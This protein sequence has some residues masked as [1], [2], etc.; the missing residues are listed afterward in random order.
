M[1]N[2]ILK[3]ETSR[4]EF[5][6]ICLAKIPNNIFCVKISELTVAKESCRI[7]SPRQIDIL[8]ARVP[9]KSTT[10]QFEN[11]FD[12]V[13]GSFHVSRDRE[14]EFEPLYSLSILSIEYALKVP[15]DE[16]SVWKLRADDTIEIIRND[17]F[18]TR[19]VSSTDKREQ[20]IS[21]VRSF[22]QESEETFSHSELLI[23]GASIVLTSFE[24]KAEWLKRPSFS[25]NWEFVENSTWDW[26]VI[27]ELV[28]FQEVET[29]KVLY[30]T[31]ENV[32]KYGKMAAHFRSLLLLRSKNFWNPKKDSSNIR[33][34]IAFF[35]WKT[36]I[37]EEK[38]RM[39]SISEEER[40]EELKY[41]EKLYKEYFRRLNVLVLLA[42]RRERAR[43]Q[44]KISFQ[45]LRKIF[46]RSD[47]FESI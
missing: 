33:E 42:S 41:F 43:N 38:F 39:G 11:S 25:K 20:S 28:Q 27:N 34:F 3:S 7:C 9:K 6:Y 35:V 1:T 40:R 21:M 36:R 14:P 23:L 15:L 26:Q 37:V 45:K 22:S 47:I 31:E 18:E 46:K 29:I 32:K 8:T 13:I 5:C 12:P 4:N 10:F 30:V 44:L 16:S 24:E 17:Q 19:K 2:T